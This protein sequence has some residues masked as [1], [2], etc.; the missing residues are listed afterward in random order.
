MHILVPYY[1]IQVFYNGVGL[2]KKSTIH[3]HIIT[4]YMIEPLLINACIGMEWGKWELHGLMGHHLWLNALSDQEEVTLT[5]S[6]SKARRVPFGG[7]PTVH[8]SEVLFTGRWSF[9]PEKENHIHSPN[10]SAK[11]PFFLVL[12][13][14]FIKLPIFIFISLDNQSIL[15]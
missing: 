2:H 8:G 13:T 15:P 10:P 5:V 11:F 12:A 7:T 4:I 9:V 3:V 6:S 14:H 1:N